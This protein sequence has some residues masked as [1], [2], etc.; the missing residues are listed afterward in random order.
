[1]QL[2]AQYKSAT[3]DKHLTGLRSF[4]TWTVKEG[5]LKKNQHPVLVQNVRGQC[6]APHWLHAKKENRPVRRAVEDYGSKRDDAI[7]KMLRHTGLG[8][9]KLCALGLSDIQMSVRQG[10]VIVRSG[11]GRRY[12]EVGLNKKVRPTLKEYLAGRP[13]TDDTHIIIGKHSPLTRQGVRKIVEK[14]GRLAGLEKVSAHMLRHTFGKS[15]LDSGA[16]IV[17]VSDLMGHARTDSTA[18]YTRS[19]ERDREVTLDRMAYEE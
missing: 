17:L 2:K 3:I 6:Q 9:S 4:F 11:K 16:D 1:M 13:K 8:V 14:Y 12:R 15:L 7:I 18:R 5:F 10:K 19:S